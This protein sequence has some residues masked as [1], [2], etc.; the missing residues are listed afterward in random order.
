LKDEE[1]EGVIRAGLMKIQEEKNAGLKKASQDFLDQ[2]KKK[3]GV[4]VTPEGVQYEVLKEG[5]GLKATLED[6]L[7]VHYVGKIYTGEQF[8]SSY[9]RGEPLELNLK[10]MIEGWKIGI[11]LMNK[12]S[13]YRFFIPHSLGYGERASGPIPA[14]STLIFEVELLDIKSP[15]ENAI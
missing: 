9:D 12:G 8:D 14:Y 5:E 2:N 15:N 3:P 13:K 4:K 1:R 6:T 11:P 10:S 7:I